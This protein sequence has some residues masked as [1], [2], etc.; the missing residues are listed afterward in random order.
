[1]EQVRVVFDSWIGMNKNT[2]AQ[3]L[4]AFFCPYSTQ[5]PQRIRGKQGHCPHV[6]AGQSSSLTCS[7]DP[8]IGFQY[9]GMVAFV[10]K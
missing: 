3:Y 2:P 8:K 1:M 9:K 6:P 5:D 10:S 7:G 4:A